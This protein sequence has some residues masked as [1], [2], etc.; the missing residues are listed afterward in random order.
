MSSTQ[1]DSAVSARGNRLL[2]FL[3]GFFLPTVVTA[4]IWAVFSMITG[5][6]DAGSMLGAAALS[7]GGTASG[8][9][10]AAS[11]GS[12]ALTDGP[13]LLQWVVLGAVLGGS[14]TLTL[15][16]R[17]QTPGMSV[18]E[19]TLLNEN[20]GAPT[21]SQALKRTAVL[22]APLPVMALVSVSIPLTGLPIALLLL[23]GWLGVE[24]VTLFTD[25][26]TQ[27][28]G[29]RLADTVVVVAPA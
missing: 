11:L 6:V 8:V 20:G 13:R 21:Q 1:L 22:L 27:R 18:T 4:V 3:I 23:V 16:N 2:A 5:I 19:G 14:F 17:G 12:M 28:L 10:T 24:A 7:D 9:G 25:D 29:D 15:E 26:S